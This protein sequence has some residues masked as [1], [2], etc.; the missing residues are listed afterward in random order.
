MRPVRVARSGPAHLPT[1]LHTRRV[2]RPLP[3]V[4]KPALS[5]VFCGIN[6]GNQAALEGHHFAGRNNRFWRVLQL[7]GFTPHEIAAEYDRSLLA[8]HC[9]LTTVVERPTAGADELARHE[10]TAASARLERKIRRYAPT[11]VAF[12]GKAAYAAMTGRNELSWG[13]Q[14]RP[15]GGAR[16]WILPNPSGRNRSFTLDALVI[17]YRELRVTL[18]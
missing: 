16:V 8:Y 3:D 11:V 10:F 1:N 5:V 6:P 2:S 17:A 15:F 7:A 18:R 14:P 4:L 12:L 9:G 13:E